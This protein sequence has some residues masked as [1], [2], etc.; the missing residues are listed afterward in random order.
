MGRAL[1][2]RMGGQ[3]GQQGLFR[4]LPDDGIAADQRQRRI[5]RPDRD[6]KVEG[7]NDA[8]NAQRVPGFHHPVVGALGGNRQAEQLAR[9]TDR[10]IAN[11][12][13]FLHFAKAFGGDLSGFERH[14]TAQIGLGGAQFFAQQAH[15][16]ATARRGH[17][18]PDFESGFG[19]AQL[20]LCVSQRGGFNRG[21]HAAVNRRAGLDG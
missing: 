8:A 3:G 14:Q 15:E 10:I 2:N 5:P 11:I 13:H 20:R 4:R 6:R 16:F 17:L 21:N 19:F 1:D 18:A 9:Q 7:R 12:D